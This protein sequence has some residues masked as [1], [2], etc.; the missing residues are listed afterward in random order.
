M[1]IETF[2]RPDAHML[3]CRVDA[4]SARIQQIQQQDM[5]TILF[6]GCSFNPLWPS[7]MLLTLLQRVRALST[8]S[9]LLSHRA[10][11][12][13]LTIFHALPAEEKAPGLQD[14]VLDLHTAHAS[15]GAT[16]KDMIPYVPPMWSNST[17]D[18]IPYT[19]PPLPPQSTNSKQKRLKTIKYVQILLISLNVYLRSWR[20]YCYSFAE[21]GTCKKGASCSYP[22][23]DIATV[24]QIANEGKHK[25]KKKKGS[26]SM[27]PD[28]GEQAAQ[29]SQIPDD[30]L[31]IMQ[32]HV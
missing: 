6:P 21:T 10:G 25:K 7:K 3:L 8:G 31:Y 27:A 5:R 16:N 11:E 29:S 22:H 18:R 14:G 1:W 28:E 4:Q 24:K 26:K 2:I 19:F 15:S 17:P 23:L 9:Y 32:E 12:G 30:L 20:R 13:H